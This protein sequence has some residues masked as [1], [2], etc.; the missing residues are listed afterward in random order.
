M[1]PST[2]SWEKHDIVIVIFRELK[3]SYTKQ[4]LRTGKLK[5]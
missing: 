5:N 4:Y 3:A 2:L 1:E